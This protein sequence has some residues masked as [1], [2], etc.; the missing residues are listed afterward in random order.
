[1]V[2]AQKF[3]IEQEMT[4]LVNELDKSYLRKMQIDKCT[5]E[6]EKCAVKCVDKHIAIIPSMMK[7]MK[8]VLASGKPPPPKAN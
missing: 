4:N 6:F 5:I 8:A 7:T 2:E 1:M 3:R